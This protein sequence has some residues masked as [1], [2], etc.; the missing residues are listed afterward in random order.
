MR[1][2]SILFQQPGALSFIELSMHLYAKTINSKLLCLGW[3]LF[4]Q[5]WRGKSEVTF[6][7]TGQS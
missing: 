3:L 1:S 7:T 4:L 5:K 6:K 2:P